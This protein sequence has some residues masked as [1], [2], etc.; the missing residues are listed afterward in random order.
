MKVNFNKTIKSGTGSDIL[1]TV[2]TRV[3]SCLSYDELLALENSS[4]SII[5]IKTAIKDYTLANSAKAIQTVHDL[6]LKQLN[7]EISNTYSL[8][9]KFV[10]I[11]QLEIKYPYLVSGVIP[12]LVTKPRLKKIVQRVRIKNEVR[13]TEDSIADL[14]KWN[15][16]LTS[17]VLELYTALDLTDS[18]NISPEKK[19]L[20]ELAKVKFKDTETWADYL[21]SNNDV[22]FIDKIM[23]RENKIKSI[24]VEEK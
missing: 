18:V 23:S 2:K 19:A 6:Y 16:L 22:S 14:A 13:S 10:D 8:E 21:V 24:V 15:S 11:E 9:K 20:I 1:G 5:G 12:I 17:F 4:V 3:Y 7:R